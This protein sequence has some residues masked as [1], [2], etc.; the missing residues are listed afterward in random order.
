M[1]GTQPEPKIYRLSDEHDY[2]WA[3]LEDLAPETPSVP[4]ELK[5]FFPTGETVDEVG[6]LHVY[7]HSSPKFASGDEAVEATPQEMAEWRAVWA[8]VE[9]AQQALRVRLKG[10][11]EAYEA[12]AKEALADLA[13]AMQPWAAVETV[14]KERTAAL[15]ATLHSHRQAAEKWQ[16][17]QEKKQQEHLDTI[18][19]PR[20]VV[21][22]K[23]K[24]LSSHNKADHVARVHLVTC[25]RR[26]AK[27]AAVGGRHDNDEG[28]RAG[29]AWK[30]LTSP[31][32]WTRGY[33][34]REVANLRVKFCSF[35]RPWTVFE[36]HIKD[37]PRPRYSSRM[38]PVLGEV[39][40]TEIP[41][42]WTL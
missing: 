33:M 16:A 13:T 9:Q 18:E 17:E 14:L 32:D 25:K 23:P 3:D 11:Q 4:D 22:Y 19:G 7:G 39:M 10:A 26:A 8:D 27:S 5:P 12:A 42:N 41:D 30:R 6:E 38:T 21:L 37:F 15:A 2:T 20:T 24:R 29:E 31:R 28:L 40:L 35:C 34:D 1:P 36:E